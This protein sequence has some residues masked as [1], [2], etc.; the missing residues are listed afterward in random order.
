MRAIKSAHWTKFGM[1]SSGSGILWMLGW[2]LWGGLTNVSDNIPDSGTSG[3]MNGSVGSGMVSVLENFPEPLR[4]ELNPSPCVDPSSQSLAGFAGQNFQSLDPEAVR[5]AIRRGADY[6]ISRQNEDGS[7]SGMFFE[8]GTTALCTLAL[9]EALDDPDHPAIRRAISNLLQLKRAEN[10]ATYVVS[11]RIMALAAAD[12]SGQKYR[13]EIAAD[14]RWLLESQLGKPVSNLEGGWSYGSRRMGGGDSSNS[15]F[16]LLALHEASR[17]GIPVPKK[18]W[19]AAAEYWESCFDPKT[20][21]FSYVPGSRSPTHSMTC[22]GIASSII[23][24]ENLQDVRQWI[25]GDHARCCSPP[26]ANPLVEQG[27]SWLAKNYAPQQRIYSKGIYFYYMYGLERIGRMSGQRFIGPHDWYRDGTEALLKSQQRVNGAWNGQGMGENNP[28]VATAFALL[29]LSKGKRPIAIGHYQYG[30]QGQLDWNQHPLGVHYLTVELER[31]WNQ[32]LNWQT[33]SGQAATVDDLLE[34]PVLFISGK[35]SL[36]LKPEQQQA[37][38]DYLENGGFLFVEACRDEGCGSP[39]FDQQFRELMARLFPESELEPLGPEHLIWNSHFALSPNAERPLLGLNT[40]CRTAVVYCPANL[41]CYWQLNQPA[42]RERASEGLQN[43]VD[44]CSQ[45]GVNVVAYATGR[46]LKDKGEYARVLEGG[47]SVLTDRILE[48]PKLI[49]SGGADDAKTA[50]RNLLLE[51]RNQGLKVSLEKKLIPPELEK[52][53]DFP[54]VFMHGSSGFSFTDKQRDD[55]RQYLRAGGF[56]FVDSICSS[57]SFSEAF[58]KEIQLICQQPLVPLSP[59]HEIW[60]EAYGGRLERVTRQIRDPQQGG[61]RS[62]QHPPQLEGVEM[63]GRLSVLFSPIDLSCAWESVHS[64]QC[65]GYQ[66]EDALK[67]GMK[68]ILYSLNR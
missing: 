46:N 7:W 17:L 9:I 45:L 11:L 34:T 39:E 60:G 14:T 66:H 21:G 52:L 65:E 44:Y 68:V 58:R 23:I 57:S 41:S 33:I 61:F 54:F 64:S 10:S 67:I 50:L 43:R 29:F 59:D 37:L 25:N 27:L 42:V 6:L 18:H 40:C 1:F 35:N 51:S 3:A 13:R 24:Q 8:G 31:Q 36:D 26:P 53:I 47:V 19:R 56:L 16:A 2:F 15:Q 48:F 28:I 32:R 20:G 55:L 63:D 38:K 22:A 30:D 62:D 12:R 49:H 5:R 4:P